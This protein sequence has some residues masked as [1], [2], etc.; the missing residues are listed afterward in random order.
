MGLSN[1]W[2]V[3]CLCIQYV[4]EHFSFV[5]SI[6]V[7][8]DMFFILF[9]NLYM[10]TCGCAVQMELNEQFGVQELGPVSLSPRA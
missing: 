2:F 9:K 10:V 6:E 8:N 3:V 4:I 5:F 1:V 7:R